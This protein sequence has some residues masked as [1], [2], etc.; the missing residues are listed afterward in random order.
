MENFAYLPMVFSFLFPA[1]EIKK[2]FPKLVWRKASLQMH[3]NEVVFRGKSSLPPEIR[4]LKTPMEVFLYFFNDEII[5]IIVTET[6]AAAR[7]ENPETDF[8]TTAQEIY[9][10]IGIL[11]YTSVYQ[12]PNIEE[13]WSTTDG[14]PPI[15]R[16]MP[17]KRF[18]VIKKWLCFHD[19]SQRKRKGEA[20]HDPLFRIRK[21]SDALNAQF[22]TVPKTARLCQYMPAKP[23]KW[24]VKLFVICDSH[25]FA[26]HFEIYTGAGS[27]T[28][29]PNTP[30][31]GASA[32][33]VIR[34]SQTVPDFVNHIIYFDNM[35]TTIPLL[36]YLRSRGIFALG[37]IRANRIQNC[38]LPKDE[39]VKEKPRGHAVEY[40]GNAQGVKVSTVLWKD[41]KCVRLAST[42]VGEKPFQSAN[43]D[44]QPSKASRYDR[45]EHNYIEIGC[46]QIIKEYNRHMGG[47]DLMDGLMGRYHV[48]IKSMDMMKLLF[49]H[50]LDMATTNAY[51]LYR[52]IHAEKMNDSS[53][54]TP[55]E[56]DL[57]TLPMFRKNVARG[58]VTIGER[59]AAG[60]PPSRGP[61][62]RSNSPVPELSAFL[63][64]GRKSEHPVNDLRYDGIDHMSHWLPREKGGKAKCKF[65]KHSETQHTCIKCKLHLCNTA[66]KNCFAEYHRK[67]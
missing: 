19:E 10:F 14:F 50:L 2:N 29:L 4:E 44:S 8:E 62:S 13:Y 38:K 66:A 39:D 17:I 40:V 58:L 61:D 52:R 43:P 3:V 45:K 11:I 32:N 59:R 37:T 67:E 31:L 26:Y 41:S 5:D 34:L 46:P 47:V 15:Q 48:S 35:Y 57:L 27:D 55:D 64:K 1:T 20:G 49:Y 23:H 30:D 24:G 36:V 63:A 65:C 53:N 21:I 56:G 28:V 9:R 60:R 42:Y 7:R 25:G 16:T 6:N 12:Y 22:D 51:I 33:I 18:M 54:V